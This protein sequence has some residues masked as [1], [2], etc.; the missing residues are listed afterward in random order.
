MR[1]PC[2]RHRAKNS[3]QK[4]PKS[5]GGTSGGCVAAAREGAS[6]EHEW[7]RSGRR[8]VPYTPLSGFSS[9]YQ[10]DKKLLGVLGRGE[11]G[12]LLNN[13]ILLQWW[14]QSVWVLGQIEVGP[15]SGWHLPSSEQQEVDSCPGLT[16]LRFHCGNLLK[17][18]Q[19]GRSGWRMWEKGRRQEQLE[20]SFVTLT[21]VERQRHQREFNER[22]G[23]KGSDGNEYKHFQRNLLWRGTRKW[24]DWKKGEVGLRDILGA[25]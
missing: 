14:A 1:E 13:I 2:S 16:S 5:I 10:Q 22:I 17:R 9:Y 4:H 15:P 8:R 18:E 3:G 12:F 7:L 23:K 20:L 21:R 25:E 24:G 11:I 6:G 19:I